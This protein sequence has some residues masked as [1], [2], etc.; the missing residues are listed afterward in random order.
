MLGKVE[1]KRCC[2]ECE[3]GLRRSLDLMASQDTDTISL[4]S[5]HDCQSRGS[6]KQNP[7]P[8]SLRENRMEKIEKCTSE[9]G[10]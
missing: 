2:A 3:E 10:P 4:D 6:P 9:S 1:Y 8:C 5:R 7:A